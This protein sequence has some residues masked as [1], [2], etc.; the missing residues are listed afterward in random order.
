MLRAVVLTVYIAGLVYFLRAVVC[1][2]A[3]S[4]TAGLQTLV[5]GG[6]FAGLYTALNLAS[7]NATLV[8]SAGRFEEEEEKFGSL[9]LLYDV[10]GLF[11]DSEWSSEWH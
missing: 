3:V 9:P 7:S 5:L 6:G 10:A 1:F 8:D 2:L 11:Q 4:R